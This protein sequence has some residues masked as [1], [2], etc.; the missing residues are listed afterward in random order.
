MVTK[1]VFDRSLD[2]GTP[3]DHLNRAKADVCLWLVNRS[4]VNQDWR[5]LRGTGSVFETYT[6]SEL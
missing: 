4:V 1:F 2:F 3:D 5:R 6:G